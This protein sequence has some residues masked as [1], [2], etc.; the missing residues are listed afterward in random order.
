MKDISNLRIGQVVELSDAQAH[1]I[2]GVLRLRNGSSVRIFDGSSGEFVAEV[3]GVGKGRRKQNKG[4]DARSSEQ[5]S[6]CVKHLNRS[7]A[8]QGCIGV[9]EIELIFSPIRKQRLK[10]LVEKA[11]EVGASRLTPVLTHR[12]QGSAADTTSLCKIG[13]TVIEAAEQCER[14]DLPR[15][16]T[17]PIPLAALL[18]AWD[19]TY[20]SDATSSDPDFDKG[21]RSIVEPSSS[22]HNTL[23]VCKERDIDAPPLLEALADFVKL[24][25]RDEQNGCRKGRVAFLVGPEGGFAP[26]EMELMAQCPSVHFVSLGP[27]VLRAETAALY[28]LSCWS[29]FWATAGPSRK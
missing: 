26:E 5:P 20:V 10:A 9:P 8:A 18:R 17:H 12:T 3:C 4:P 23:F 22:A 11:V 7:Q 21:R 13:S 2:V 25:Q 15:V 19:S 16:K 29:A 14:M 24:R 6:L 28:A 1:Y 27:T